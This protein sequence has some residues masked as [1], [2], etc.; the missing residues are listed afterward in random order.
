MVTVSKKVT[1]TLSGPERNYFFVFLPIVFSQNIFQRLYSPKSSGDLCTLFSDRNLINRRNVRSDVQQGYTQCKEFF[2][3]EFES[4]VVAAAFQI[5]G[6]SALED[7]PS[8]HPLPQSVQ[9]NAQSILGKLYLHKVSKAILDTFCADSKSAE[10]INSV[11]DEEE[12]EQINAAQMISPDGRFMCRFPGCPAT[13]KH[14]GK[15]RRDHEQQHDPPPIIPDVVVSDSDSEKQVPKPSKRDDAYNYNCCLLSYGLLFTEFIDAV[16][17]GDGER[18]LRCWKMFILHFKN[19][20]GSTK[21]A[22]EAL[23]YSLQVNSLLTP[24]QAYRLKWNRSVRGKASNVPLDLDLEH[25]N[26]E[27][28]EE[29]RELKRNVTEKAVSRL[30]KTLFIK[31]RMV[32]SYDDCIKKMKQSGKHTVRSDSK[33]FSTVLNKLVAEGVFQFKEGRS[34]NCFPGITNGPLDGLDIHTVYKWINEHK[35]YIALDKRAR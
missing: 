7:L 29:V 19:D 13:F 6:M 34:Y 23:Y 18:N 28:K 22:V 14:D 21:Y 20:S 26:K 1:Q 9:G 15:R 5:L 30:C 33:D 16:A 24:R 4:R 10:I 32:G 12:M 27:L 8:L 35:K 31:R 2:L 17:E 25:D 3:L 11:L